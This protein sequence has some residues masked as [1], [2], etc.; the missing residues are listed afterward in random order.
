MQITIESNAD[1][2]K[3]LRRFAPD[4]EKSL[5]KEI[6]LALRPVVKQARGFVPGSSPL[7][8]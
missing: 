5:K 4:L 1:F 6:G 2:R 3:A 7:S 8:G